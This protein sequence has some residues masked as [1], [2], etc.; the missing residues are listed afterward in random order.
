MDAE[1]EIKKIEEE[2]RKTPYNKA[3]QGHIGRLKAKLARLREASA[4]KSGGS[5]LGY[6]VRKLGD[7][8]VIL[9]GFP[10]VGKSTLLNQ[11]TNAESRVAEYEFTTL[12]V[13]PGMLEFRGARI[14]VLD[15]PG[16][17][18]SA[19]EGKGRGKEV[20]SV[21]RNA[22]LLLVIT[23][24]PDF[25]K[26]KDIIEKELYNGNFRLNQKPPDIKI[27]KKNEGGIKVEATGRLDF[28]RDTIV[29]I[30]KEF[31]IHN[32]EIL[33]R[34]KVSLDQL[35]DSMSKNRVYLPAVF[36][37]NK[38]DI[39]LCR[40]RGFLK[41]SALKKEGI[42]ELKEKIWNELGL[43]RIF[44]KKPGKPPDMEEPLIVR[45]VV[46]VRDICEKLRLREHFKFAKIWG[47]SSRFP[48]Q[49]A[50]LE[51]KLRDRDVLEVHN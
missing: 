2:I 6:A 21:V 26:Q 15:I 46:R 42:E 16:V 17:I 28:S 41:I 44:L 33:I 13:I 3:T 51:K 9:V 30:L 8:T 25:R 43:K 19:S 10:S 24:G 34:E 4:K 31:K 5:G 39:H 1:E 48:G 20:L 47:P 49:K 50:G 11:L 37:A 7:A 36:V 27:T 18:E 40:E 35:I 12:N 32:A 22:D 38:T 23:S 29:Q 14:Q 45:G